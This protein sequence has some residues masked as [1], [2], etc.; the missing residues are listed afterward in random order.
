MNIDTISEKVAK[1]IG[2]SEYQVREINRSQWKFLLDTIQS[3]SFDPVH[4]IYIGK[5]HKNS[6]YDKDRIK[7]YTPNSSGL[8]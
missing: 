4:L 5:F 3:G 7:R 2:L 1:D 8:H 6:R